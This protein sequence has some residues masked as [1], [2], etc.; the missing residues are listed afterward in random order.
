MAGRKERESAPAP[1]NTLIARNKKAA[2]KFHLL[3]RFEAGLVL[4]GSEIKSIRARKVSLDQSFG[5]VRNGEL[6]LLGMNIAPY[7]KAGYAQHEPLRPRKLLLHRREASRIIGSL[8]QSGYTLVPTALY[9]KRGLAKV[10]VALARGKRKYDRREEIR[11]R[12]AERDIR[13][14]LSRQRRRII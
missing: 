7:E 1:Q 12:D 10:E 14:A 13:R 8:T 9:L 6:Y 4:Q 11:R 3:E 2:F 5:R